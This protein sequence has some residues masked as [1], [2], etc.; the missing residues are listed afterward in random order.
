MGLERKCEVRLLQGK[1]LGR[2]PVSSAPALATAC[3]L[4][5]GSAQG[6]S[7]LAQL[8]PR[9]VSS[10]PALP[11]ACL[12]FLRYVNKSRAGKAEVRR[13]GREVFFV[14]KMNICETSDL[15]KKLH[16]IY[17]LVGGTVVFS[18]SSFIFISCSI[19]L[20]QLGF[21][22]ASINKSSLMF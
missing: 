2:G 7:P 6:M 19:C 12:L 9:H 18:S 1:C 8:W 20:V 16:L 5:P 15:V 13:A 3:L 17:L 14:A 21:C 11:K 22:P 10:G 4:W